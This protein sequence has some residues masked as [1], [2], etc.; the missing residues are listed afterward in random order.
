MQVGNSDIASKGDSSRILIVE[1]NPEN[2]QLLRL[3]MKKEPWR[4][5]AA[6][7][8]EEALAM[9]DHMTPDLVLLDIALPGM[10]GVEACREIKGRQGF[11]DVPVIFATVSQNEISACFDAGGSD[12]ITKPI[13]SEQ[14]VSRVR[15]H[16]RTRSQMLDLRQKIL[17]QDSLARL[18]KRVSEIT[19]EV[20]TP[21]G[22]C[23]T[24]ASS[25]V[26]IEL[27]FQ[28]AFDADSLTRE[29]VESFLEQIKE[30]GEIIDR[31][32]SEAA[33]L[34]GNFKELAVDES[35]NRIRSIAL[36]EYVK[37]IVA[38]LG[39]VIEDAGIE[40]SI[41]IPSTLSLETI[42]G[43]LAQILRNL[44]VNSLV[45]GFEGKGG[46]NISISAQAGESEWYLHYVDD[47]VGM[48]EDV[49]SHVFEK[50]FTTKVEQGGSGVGAHIIKTRTQLL[51]GTVDLQSKPG[52]GVQYEF[53]FPNKCQ[54]I[55]E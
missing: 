51:G 34:M 9:L 21:L 2:L 39:S 6:T 10:N 5:S 12:Y 32:I 17:A 41:E 22:I 36:S 30:S 18:G 1:D 49:Y 43:S 50:Y 7:S 11:A 37:K 14:L 8:A 42:P 31:N 55:S 40:I 15:N 19:H 35:S 25:L 4:I 26:G 48:S 33:R 29:D 28:E 20:N 27:K 54:P 44:I 47:G 53:C 24:A 23:V 46:G 38:D 3:Q 16:L 13:K 45:H 52:Q